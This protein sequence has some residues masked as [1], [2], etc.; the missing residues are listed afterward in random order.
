[1]PPALVSGVIGSKKPRQGGAA[2]LSDHCRAH[3]RNISGSFAILTAIRRP[4]SR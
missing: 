4:S 1:M 3:L 2:F